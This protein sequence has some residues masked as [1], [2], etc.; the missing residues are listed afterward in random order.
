[1]LSVIYRR[2]KTSEFNTGSDYVTQ[3]IKDQWQ[4]V[5]RKP[6][7]ELCSK[8]NTRITYKFKYSFLLSGINITLFEASRHS[9]ENPFHFSL[10]SGT[11]CLWSVILWINFIQAL[12]QWKQPYDKVKGQISKSNKLINVYIK[13]RINYVKCNKK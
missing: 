11:N 12:E 5:N 4:V 9:V 3:V 6:V 2:I 7:F 8:K 10:C 1:M 13:S